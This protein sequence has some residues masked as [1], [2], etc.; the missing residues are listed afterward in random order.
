MKK[1]ILLLSALM[2]LTTAQN[3]VKAQDLTLSDVQNSGCLRDSEYG[4][5]RANAEGEPTRTIILLKEGNILT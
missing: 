4:R 1:A 3:V 5:R 2:L